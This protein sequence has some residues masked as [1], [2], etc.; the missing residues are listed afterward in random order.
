MVC[1]VL[2]GMQGRIDATRLFSDRLF[3]ILLKAG[4]MRL[5]WDRQIVV[6]HKGPGTGTDNS[7]TQVVNAL[8]NAADTDGQSPPVGWAMIGWHVDDG[9]GVACDVHH[10]LDPQKNRVV[11][12]LKGQVAIT[13][14]TTLTGWHGSK[15]LGFLL[16]QNDEKRTVS[17]SAPDALAQAVKL[18]TTDSMSVSPKHVRSETAKLITAGVEPASGDPARAPFL[19][20]QQKCRKIL[21]ICIWL[22]N[23]YA[24]I[25]EPTNLLCAHMHSPSEET[26][27][28]A[29]HMLMH[30]SKNGR[31]NTYG[32]WGI[33]GL[34]TPATRVP[35]YAAGR[36][37][38]SFHFF[39]DA[40]VNLPS[41]SGGVGMLA[42]GPVIARSQRLHLSA[43]NSHTTEVVSAGDNLNLVIPTNG[44]L[45]EVRIRLGVR[46]A[47]YLDSATTVF[48][49]TDDA[50]ARKSAWLIRRVQVLRESTS[51]EIEP[52]H[53]PERKMAAD[54]F[55]KYLSYEV[56]DRHMQYVMNYNSGHP[57]VE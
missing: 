42:G 22:S 44:L 34:E 13:Y 15:A 49:A 12:Y 1:E 27:K 53:I 30:K 47:Y 10:C 28:H 52:I 24:D 18:V 32:G 26:L 33:E 21:G 43:P 54:P 19:L 16:T 57:S 9:C 4:C 50:A 5:M 17:M 29:T 56:W 51:D 55:T 39:S 41:T 46:T 7:L 20:M 45:Q 38:M 14:A 31:C 3:K 48:V 35:P 11:Q 40:D 6:Y 23:A 25:V 2:V 8:H 36:K 37:D